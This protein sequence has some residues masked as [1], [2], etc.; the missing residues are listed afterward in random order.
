MLRIFILSLLFSAY[1][2]GEVCAQHEGDNWFFGLGAGLTFASGAPLPLPGGQI[3]T[4]EGCATISD[5]AGSLLFYTDGITVWNKIHQAMPNGFSLLGDPSSTS[6]GIIVP[7]PGA[8]G[9]FY[10]FTVPGVAPGN[11]DNVG[12]C[13]SEVDMALNGGL[14]DVLSQTKNTYLYSPATEKLT[15][16]RYNDM[17]WV[18]SHESYADRFFAYKVT[19]AGID[20]TPVIT[21]VGVAYSQWQ[22]GAGYMKVS[23][24]GKFIGSAIYTS[25]GGQT[26]NGELYRFD[27]VT[28]VVSNP[29]PLPLE[30]QTYGIEFSPD[31]TRAYFSTSASLFQFDLTAGSDDAILASQTTLFTGFGLDVPWGMQLGPDGKLYVA[32][33]GSSSIGRIAN[34][35]V[36]GAGANYQP[37]SVSLGGVGTSQ[38]GLPTFLQTYFVEPCV[39]TNLRFFSVFRKSY[40]CSDCADG[41]ISA[42]AIS[43]VPPYTYSID[44]ANY[45]PS[46]VFSGLPPG[47][48]QVYVKDAAGCIIKRKVVLGS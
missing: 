38:Y 48:Y 44:G 4:S 39:N 29:I 23:P 13:Y 28:G 11:P 40:V 16:F 3:S 43:G 35:N 20:P 14:G 24:T 34:P 5:A 17:Y 46:G 36:Y 31:G 7:K 22:N 12:L 33:P 6:S 26:I 2:M 19:S 45:Q 41:K 47:V 8:P 9:R 10:I 42:A 21:T 1:F 25:M 37:N 27:P 15:G 30:G 32:H 18:L